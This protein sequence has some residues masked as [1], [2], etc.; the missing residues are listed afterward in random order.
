M[1]YAYRVDLKLH[2]T[3]Y[4]TQMPTHMNVEQLG[5]KINVNS[6]SSQK[7]SQ[8]IISRIYRYI[9][10]VLSKVKSSVPTWYYTKSVVLLWPVSITSS[11][12]FHLF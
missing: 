2:Y 3:S 8:T 1:L 7:V 11:N 10:H 5:L 4:M 12:E 9:P 6:R